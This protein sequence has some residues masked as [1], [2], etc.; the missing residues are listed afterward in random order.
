MKYKSEN[1]REQGSLNVL[2][3]GPGAIEKYAS[4]VDRSAL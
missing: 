4:P 2:E 3:V 1:E